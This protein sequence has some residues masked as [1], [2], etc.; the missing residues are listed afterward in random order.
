MKVALVILLVCVAGTYAQSGSFVGLIENLSNTL[1][2]TINNLLQSVI[3]LLPNK[4]RLDFSTLLATLNLQEIVHQFIDKIKETLI[5]MVTQLLGGSSKSA[6]QIKVE[7]EEK[8]FDQLGDLATQLGALVGNII[9]TIPNL[10]S[11]LGKRDLLGNLQGQ[12]QSVIDAI[13]PEINNI[14]NSILGQILSGKRDAKANAILDFILNAFN[15]SGVWD[16]ISALGSSVVAQFTAIA[17]QLLFAGTQ[18][19]NNAKPIFAQLVADLTNHAGDAVTIVAQAIASLNQVIGSA[20]KRAIAQRDLMSTI[21]TSLG[22]DQVWSTITSLGSAVYLQ[23]IN[24]G[25]QLLFAGSQ[26]WAAVKPVLNQLKDDLLNHTGDAVTIVAQ[27]IASLNQIIGSG[28][29]DLVSTIVT[30]LGLDQVWTTITSLGSA[31]YLQFVQIGTQ[32]L[33]AGQQIWAQAQVV[34]NQLKNDLLNHTGDAVTIVAQA[35]A[36]L[37]QILG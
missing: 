2:Q 34:L 10:G 16:T 13:K 21:V 12:I 29:R 4:P 35:I 24:I 36:S 20:G 31:V 33:F 7:T 3:S 19:W 23:F 9:S 25:T 37:N 15:L 28:K 22:L 32:L 5:G 26:V 27:A 14:I 1:Q 8:I 6:L 11:L 30:S 18:V 17:S